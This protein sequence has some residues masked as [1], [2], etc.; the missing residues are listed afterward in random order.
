MV[1]HP[2]YG[3][4]T[5]HDD[6]KQVERK[7]YRQKKKKKKKKKKKQERHQRHQEVDSFFFFF[8]ILTTFCLM[9]FFNFGCFSCFLTFD[10]IIVPMTKDFQIKRL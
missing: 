4:N 5:A 2:A 6:L 7:M 10:M 1:D 9:L 3:I 8:F